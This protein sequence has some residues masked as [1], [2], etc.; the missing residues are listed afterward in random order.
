MHRCLPWMCRKLPKAATCMGHTQFHQWD[1][2]SLV[3]R[4]NF[5]Q[6]TI[7]GHRSR[8]FN[9]EPCG[10]RPQDSEAWHDI[11][12]FRKFDGRS[13]GYVKVPKAMVSKFKL[14]KLAHSD[15]AL[16]VVMLVLVA[17][18]AIPVVVPMTMMVPVVTLMMPTSPHVDPRPRYHALRRGRCPRLDPP[19]PG[20]VR[21]SPA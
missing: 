17:T 3:L 5:L 12:W 4:I 7:S 20:P 2:T 11:K 14:F 18:V 19:V 9:T 13:L 16:V 6:A 1:P 21:Q 15:F 10:G 8:V